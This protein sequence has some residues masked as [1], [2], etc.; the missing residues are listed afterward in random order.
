[1]MGSIPAAMAYWY[2]YEYL[3]KRWVSN[4]NKRY[5]KSGQTTQERRNLMT[6]M[7]SGAIGMIS[8]IYAGYRIPTIA[9]IASVA[10]RSPFEVIK[11]NMQIGHFHRLS[12][13][14]IQLYNVLDSW[15]SL[16]E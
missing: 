6:Y 1:M 14:I 8:P 15:V 4:N 5:S 10:I 16:N 13:S 9:E 12:E 3:K 2:T 7:I 11:Q